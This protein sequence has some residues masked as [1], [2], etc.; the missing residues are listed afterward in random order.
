M[1]QRVAEIV[2]AELGALNGKAN[3]NVLPKFYVPQAA[4]WP[5]RGIL[6]SICKM[7]TCCDTRH[8]PLTTE[9]LKKFRLRGDHG[10]ELACEPWK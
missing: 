8:P 6:P 7:A 10:D 9:V 2:E 5:H 3:G 1:D 4:P